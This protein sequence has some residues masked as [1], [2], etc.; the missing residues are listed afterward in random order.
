MLDPDFIVANIEAVKKNCTNRAVKAD[1]DEVVRLHGERKRIV[2]E[3]QLLQQRANEVSK[4]IPQTKDAAQKQELI[5]EGKSLRDKKATAE[6]QVKEVEATLHAALL[7]IPNMT[8]PAAPVGTVPRPPARSTTPCQA[9]PIS[10]TPPRKRGSS[11]AHRRRSLR[12]PYARRP[13]F[14]SN[15]DGPWSDSPSRIWRGSAFGKAGRG[16]RDR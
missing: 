12:A 8:H 4:L 5:A 13:P 16:V 15:A 3:A 11:R 10:A 14:T 9:N 2:Q 7:M 6:Q 1:V